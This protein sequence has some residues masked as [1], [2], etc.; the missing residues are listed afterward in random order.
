MNWLN[1]NE[2][3]ENKIIN[4][5]NYLVS[6]KKGSGKFERPIRA[7][8]IA[9]EDKMYSMESSHSIPVHCDIYMELPKVPE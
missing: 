7:F 8:Y 6:Y 4:N 5:E 2:R 1:W 9:C 3:G